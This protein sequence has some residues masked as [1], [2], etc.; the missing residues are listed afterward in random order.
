MEDIIDKI[1]EYTSRLEHQ[2]SSQQYKPF[3]TIYV[4]ERHWLNPLKYI[5]GKY[6]FSW[7]VKDKQS[8]GYK[9]AFEHY[10]SLVDL[11]EKDITFK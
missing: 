11:D 5:L 9:N 2:T 6:K 4:K 7:F 8:R 10:A 3:Y 1:N